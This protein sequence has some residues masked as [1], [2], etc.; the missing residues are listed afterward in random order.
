[1]ISLFR[2]FSFAVVAGIFL[3]SGSARSQ[4][5]FSVKFPSDAISRLKERNL[6]VTAGALQSIS[7]DW[8]FIA[9]SFEKAGTPSQEFQFSMQHNKLLLETAAASS[10]NEL[11]VP[12]VVDV[13]EDL[14]VKAKH[15][16]AV[17]Q[18]VIGVS[19]SAYSA[20]DLSVRTFR[21]D[22]EINGYFIGFNPRHLAGDVPEVR[23]N[24]PTSPSKGS[25]APGRYE[26]TAILNGKV[27]KRQEVSV[28]ILGQGPEINCVV[29]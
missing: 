5:S 16:E 14:S 18:T 28:G 29:P 27:V 13:A 19:A 11:S 17:N 21:K 7:T 3:F 22:R 24:N 2:F 9:S 26:M 12:L 4:D 23:F 6:P 1:M 20:V 10:L 15:I 25:L 8:S